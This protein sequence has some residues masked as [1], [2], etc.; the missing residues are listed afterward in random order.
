MIIVTG[1]I[2]SRQHVARSLGIS[3]IRKPRPSSPP[4]GRLPRRRTPLM[5]SKRPAFSPREL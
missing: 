3:P 4:F 5:F 1:S 2:L